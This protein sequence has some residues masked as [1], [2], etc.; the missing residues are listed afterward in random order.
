MAAVTFSGFNNIDFNQVV[1]AIMAQE[2]QPLTRLQTQ[3]S[4]LETQKTAFGTLAS[5]LT[6]VQ[7]ALDTLGSSSGVTALTATSSD[8]GALSA[9]ASGG[10]VEGAYDVVVSAI[11]RRQ[12][13]ASITTPPYSS[14]DD[15]VATGGT[16]TITG[17]DGTSAVVTVGAVMTVKDLVDAINA[18]DAPVSASLV[19]SAPGSYQIVLTGR[20]S[21][22]ANAFTVSHALT[23]GAGLAL[24]D[25]DGDGISG[26]DAADNIQLARNAQFTVN[27]LSIVSDSNTVSE[28]IP[29]ATLTL[30]REDPA[31]TIAVTVSRDTATVTGRVE[32]LVTAYNDLVGFLGDQ[33]SAAVEGRTN[34]AR[35]PLVNGLKNALRGA[36]LGAHANGGDFGRL[37]EVGIGFDQTGKM[38]LDKKTFETSL[39]THPADVQLLF[40]GDDGSGGAFGSIGN[41]IESYTRS[42]G[43]V[44]DVRQR[45]S[46]QMQ[47]LTRR[48]DTLEAQLE[49]RRETL[50]REFQAADETMAQLNAQ[51]SS[52][53]GLGGQ[54][55]LF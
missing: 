27:G 3:Q 30:T 47:S 38:V 45:I 28:V 22:E 35:D 41:L 50:Q 7:S 26:D 11:A 44:A 53:S 21:G 2:R 13:M 49:R 17:A 33:R 40:S 6:A 43:L 20:R 24:P 32:K 15:V 18:S 34:I 31:A 10:A 23:G 9:S 4:A 16:V 14:T 48:I 5:R 42:G 51:M 55:R 1:S 29:G 25:G 37:A 52:L 19:Q 54:Y 39:A 36:L 46:T 8:P 12:V